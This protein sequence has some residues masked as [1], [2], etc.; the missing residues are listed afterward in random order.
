MKINRTIAIALLGTCLLYGP[1]LGEKT[2]IKTPTTKPVDKVLVTIGKTKITESQINRMLVGRIPPNIPAE[3]LKSIKKRIMGQLIQKELI[4][5]Y[6]D[7]LETTP[8]D[9]AKVKKTKEQ[10]AAMLKARAPGMTLEQFLSA[11][12]I[13]EKKLLTEPK[14]SRLMKQTVTKEK[15]AAFV[16]AGPVSY[17][18]G[19]KVRASHILIACPTYASSDEQAKA[20]AKLEKIAGDIKAGKITFK[21]AAKKYSACPS[22]DIDPARKTLGGGDL[23]EFT[24]AQMVYEFSKSA[25]SMKVDQ[26]SGIVR[27]TFGYHLIKTTGRAEGNGKV[28]QN[29]Q[30]TATK[31][32][33]GLKIEEI[34]T[35][36]TKISP[37][38]IAK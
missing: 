29:A 4:D 18:D 26:V 25:F 6:A 23:G 7:T 8:E 14:M 9:K 17:F 10:I 38:T 1:A 34:M 15:A 3:Q 24:F 13:T 22:K 32:L 27:S 11:R 31:V 28:G 33:T 16:K 12:G 2:T 30:S 37:V 36:A 35:K 20:K 21:D 5:T 19:T